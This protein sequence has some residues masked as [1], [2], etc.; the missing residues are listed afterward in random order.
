MVLV[1]VFIRYHGK[2]TSNLRTDDQNKHVR[3]FFI[4]KMT[5]NV[6]MAAEIQD[7]AKNLKRFLFI[8]IAYYGVDVLLNYLQ[9]YD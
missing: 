3:H 8:G 2:Q 4:F 1:F 9:E 6:T 7:F 5:K